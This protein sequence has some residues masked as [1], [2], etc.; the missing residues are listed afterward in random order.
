M[1]HFTFKCF[2]RFF[3]IILISSFRF[4]SFIWISFLFHLPISSNNKHHATQIPW[5]CHSQK[6]NPSRHHT[7]N[8]F[9]Q[10]DLYEFSMW[11]NQVHFD[12]P[13]M[14]RCYWLHWWIGR[15]R[16]W[17]CPRR[18]VHDPWRTW[19]STNEPLLTVVQFPI[20]TIPQNTLLFSYHQIKPN[21][22]PFSVLIAHN[23]SLKQLQF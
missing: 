13:R 17:K 22:D 1:F 4:K 10:W 15:K 11:P 2:N 12:L 20:H 5:A 3:S 21:L 9:R 19:P 8:K 14:R 6:P 16:L 18:W 7:I 23:L